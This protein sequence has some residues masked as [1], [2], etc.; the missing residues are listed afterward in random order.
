MMDG[1]Y[2]LNIIEKPIY[3]FGWNSGLGWFF[4]ILSIIIAIE[5]I[6]LTM[7]ERDGRNLL[8]LLLTFLTIIIS[9]SY[10]SSSKVIG[11]Y[12]IY[13]VTIDDTVSW[14]E[15]NERY[16]VISQRGNIIEIKEKRCKLNKNILK[17]T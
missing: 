4:V 5:S 9:A 10:F 3:G 8:F 2:I 15:L 1:I 6:H 11:T 12:N 17:I 7:I 14:V 13:E 16:D